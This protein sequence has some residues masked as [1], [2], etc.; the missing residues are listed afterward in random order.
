MAELATGVLSLVDAVLTERGEP[1]RTLGYAGDSAG[2]AVGLRLLDHP[3]RVTG[4]VLLCAGAKI[5]EPAG[6]LERAATVRRR[7]LR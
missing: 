7:A 1:G 5:G 3:D 2:G 4:A 6:W